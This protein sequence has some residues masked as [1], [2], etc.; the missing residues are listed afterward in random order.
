MADSS[1]I[2]PEASNTG[3]LENER[4]LD[5]EM[6]DAQEDAAAH[7]QEPSSSTLEHEPTQTETQPTTSLQHQNRKDTT[8]REFL[9]KMDDY[10]P[11]VCNL[12][13]LSIRAPPPSTQSSL[14][15][16]HTSRKF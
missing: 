8:L 1:E 9:S 13:S 5:A 4:D 6:D 14:I 7:T 3:D 10:A 12:L 16:S 15:L 11:I 2:L